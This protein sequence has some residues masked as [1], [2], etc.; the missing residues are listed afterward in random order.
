MEIY[1]LPLALSAV[2]FVLTI[3]LLQI[4]IPLLVKKHSGQ[5]ILEIGPNWHKSKEGTPTMGGIA[6]LLAIFLASGIFVLWAT[7]RSI[8]RIA[9]FLIVLLYGTANACIGIVDD[10]TKLTKK[11][12]LG[13]TPWQKLFLQSGFAIAFLFLLNLYTPIRTS[14][15]LPF[16]DFEL[17][18]GIFW[19]PIAFLMLLWFVNCANLT[20]GIDGLASSVSSLIGLFYVIVAIVASDISLSFAG[21]VLFGGALGFLMFNR[22]PA[23]IFMGDTGSL[24]FGALAIGCSFISGSPFLLILPGFVFLIEGLSV[25]LQVVYFKLS[26]GKRLFLMAPLHHHLEKKGY[27][28]WAITILFSLI[29]LFCSALALLIYLI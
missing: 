1:M 10:Y 17:Q 2:V 20:D 12:N 19:Y 29:T 24:F 5:T 22:H 15:T 14:L 7:T 27:S 26:H 16:L 13:L 9:P 11:R 8:G 3:M 28:E 21:A 25:V 6:P 4:I 18:L 23:R